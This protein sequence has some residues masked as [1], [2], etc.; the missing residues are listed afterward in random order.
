MSRCNLQHYAWKFSF[1]SVPWINFWMGLN[2]EWDK[3]LMD[4]VFLQYWRMLVFWDIVLFLKNCIGGGSGG[5]AYY[6][7]GFWNLSLLNQRILSYFFWLSVLW[8]CPLVYYRFFNLHASSIASNE[9]K[10]ASV[11]NIWKN[12]SNLLWFN[13]WRQLNTTVTLSLSPSEMRDENWKGKI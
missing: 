7:K 4:F 8:P 3:L 10:T 11:L 5:C 12:V 13:P 2:P 9:N 6:Y 1:S